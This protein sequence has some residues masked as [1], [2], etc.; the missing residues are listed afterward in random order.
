MNAPILWVGL[1]GSGSVLIGDHDWSSG[2]L[3]FVM[4]ARSITFKQISPEHKFGN[5]IGRF[6]G[7][8]VVQGNGPVVH[9]WLLQT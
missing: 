4:H 3:P 2:A 8:W 6:L 7:G 9:L 1:T 5:N